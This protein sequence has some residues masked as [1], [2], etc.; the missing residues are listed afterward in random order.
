MKSNQNK[1]NNNKNK[2]FNYARYS[3]IAFQMMIV[4]IAGVWGGVELDKLLNTEFP[5]LT[6]VLS[7][8]SV[9][10]AI[11]IAIKDLIK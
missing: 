6:I 10:V 9:G 11:Y 1:N 2:L 7:L 3:G 5:V 4:I 8:L